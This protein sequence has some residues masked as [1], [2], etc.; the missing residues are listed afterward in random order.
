MKKILTIIFTVLLCLNTVFVVN[1]KADDDQANNDNNQ[2]PQQENVDNATYID[3]STYSTEEQ[4]LISS[5]IHPKKITFVYDGN[6]I[7]DVANVGYVGS[8]TYDNKLNYN[9]CYYY[10]D[11]TTSPYDKDKMEFVVEFEYQGEAAGT[12]KLNYTQMD[13]NYITKTG[14]NNQVEYL[15]VMY[16]DYNLPYINILPRDIS[17]IKFYDSN[18]KEV[19]FDQDYEYGVWNRKEL[20]ALDGK[21]TIVFSVWAPNY[22]FSYAV[23]TF[24]NNETKTINYNGD[25]LKDRCYA[26]KKDGIDYNYCFLFADE[27]EDGAPESAVEEAY[28]IFGE[29]SY[30]L[31]GHDFDSYIRWN[32]EWYGDEDELNELLNAIN[33]NGIKDMGLKLKYRLKGSTDYVE[34]DCEDSFSYG[35]YRDVHGYYYEITTPVD[36]YNEIDMFCLGYC[37]CGIDASS[38]QGAY[39]YKN[40]VRYDF[41]YNADISNDYVLFYEL[42]DELDRSTL[43]DNDDIIIVID[44]E[45]ETRIGNGR[46]DC[47]CTYNFEYSGNGV[48]FTKNGNPDNIIVFV[49]DYCGNT[50]NKKTS[51]IKLFDENSYPYEIHHN[52]DGSYFWDIYVDPAEFYSVDNSDVYFDVR[53][54]NNG[55]YDNITFEQQ[56]DNNNPAVEQKKETI[57]EV[58]TVLLKIRKWSNP[59][60]NI[61]GSNTGSQESFTQ[62]HQ[63]CLQVGINDI[64]KYT[65]INSFNLASSSFVTDGGIISKTSG[66]I[67][68]LIIGVNVNKDTTDFV[69]QIRNLPTDADHT[70]LNYESNYINITFKDNAELIKKEYSVSA[71]ADYPMVTYTLKNNDNDVVQTVSFSLR[72]EKGN[73]SGQS[74]MI[75][76]NNYNCQT[77]YKNGRQYT[78]YIHNDNDVQYEKF[79]EYTG[80]QHQTLIVNYQRDNY[81][82]ETDDYLYNE[83]KQYMK[84]SGYNIEVYVPKDGVVLDGDVDVDDLNRITNTSKIMTLKYNSCEGNDY[85]GVLSDM[86]RILSNP[87]YYKDLEGNWQKVKVFDDY[88]SFESYSGN[89]VATY[90][91]VQKIGNKYQG[92]ILFKTRY[93]TYIKT[94]QEYYSD[95][96]WVSAEPYKLSHINGQSDAELFEAAVNAVKDKKF[97]KIILESSITLD[98]DVVVSHMMYNGDDIS[99]DNSSWTNPQYGLEIDLNGHNINVGDHVIDISHNSWVYF[100]NSKIETVSGNDVFLA[101]I[102]QIIGTGNQTIRNYGF[103]GIYNNVELINE[104]GTALTA[105]DISNCTY[106][107]SGSSIYA[108]K[109]IEV[110]E[111]TTGYTDNYRNE[112]GVQIHG[113]IRAYDYAVYF[114]CLRVNEYL[115]YNIRFYRDY[116]N[117]D[118]DYVSVV[119]NAYGV[120]ANG[121][122]NVELN[123][124]EMIA[125][126]PFVVNGGTYKIT[127]SNIK[128]TA[129]Y[130]VEADYTADN[131]N[132]ALFLVDSL[133]KN[134]STVKVNFQVSSRE[135]LEA[136]GPLVADT[137]VSSQS[138]ISKVDIACY[139]DKSDDSYIL[140][141]DNL[142]VNVPKAAVNIDGGNYSTTDFKNYVDTQEYLC[143]AT[144]G[145]DYGDYHFFIYRGQYPTS[146]TNETK[147]SEIRLININDRTKTYDAVYTGSHDE[148]AG[149]V[150]RKLYEFVVS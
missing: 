147:L 150:T 62:V 35:N 20:N 100:T 68:N 108:N 42:T 57:N 55:H 69:N 86:K 114:N 140:T 12:L 8:S 87:T 89:A 111:T 33:N 17:N 84:E 124:C 10:T 37:E 129:Y 117:E 91:I 72:Y 25:E 82:P 53:L 125:D 92:Y 32:F 43:T 63:F 38:I 11:N 5:I 60:F 135:I 49:I 48:W 146:L 139:N 106:I 34:V 50:E 113:D 109:A 71:D 102:S 104:Y 80:Y 23:I 58:D 18:D 128:A 137:A 118:Q 15:S 121:N 30:E 70:N 40:N 13:N 94:Y 141:G 110:C 44:D 65:L 143:I 29:D 78:L 122:V 127:D 27:L 4:T 7:K 52:D 1:V 98:R 142:F 31:I 90:T 131:P 112:V 22:N 149:N 14:D 138:K 83:G 132:G 81:N 21:D 77:F 76:G 148:T 130:D 64:L 54:A 16:S 105:Y 73:W 59:T 107:G 120:Y 93:F 134:A 66:M 97:A 123:N 126:Y 133:A 9:F 3:Y 47:R 2:E 144:R 67:N 24:D 99:G 39:I 26:F 41:I 75:N 51:F 46:N 95:E 19:T 74:I 36:N 6:E 96:N 119:S 101:A 136:E 45:T 88:D 56:E 85:D 115:K 79:F 145:D 28:I 103:V 116:K 61:I